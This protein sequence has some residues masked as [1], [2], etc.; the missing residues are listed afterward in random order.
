MA[1]DSDPFVRLHITPLDAELIKSVIPAPVLPLARKVSYHTILTFPEKRY[2]FVELP[3]AD[4]EKLKKKYN[5]VTFKGSKMRIEKARPE[6]RAQPAGDEDKDRKKRE[7]REQK[8]QKEEQEEDKAKADNEGAAK[9]SSKKRKREVDVLEG[10]ALRDRK[11]KRG[12]TE[13]AGEQQKKRRRS[14]KDDEKRED[15]GRDR[16]RDRDGK[17]KK[18][19]PQSKYTEGEECLLKVKVPPNAMKNVQP[20]DLQPSKKKKTKG[21]ARQV[22]VHEFEKTTKFPGFLRQ[23]AAAD[24][25]RAAE[26]V[27]G[28]GWVDEEGN[29]VEAVEEKKK[30]KKKEEEAEAREKPS[31]PKAKPAPPKPESDEEEDSGTSSEETSSD[32]SSSDGDSDEELEAAPAPAQSEKTPTQKQAGQRESDDEG[33][34]SSSGSS[35]SSEDEPD[36]DDIPAPQPKT[37]NNQANSA[38]QQNPSA[39]KA[40]HK[41]LA[42]HIP[43]AAETPSAPQAPHPLEALYKRAA[44]AA[45][46]PAAAGPAEPFSFFG[47]GASGDDDIDEDIEVDNEHNDIDEAADLVPDMPMTPFTR[48]DYEWRRVRSAAPT[49]DTAHPPRLQ[50]FSAS[51]SASVSNPNLHPLGT[52]TPQKQWG[53]DAYAEG[54]EDEEE[55]EALLEEDEDVQG[56]ATAASDFQKWFWENRRELNRSWM[57]RR[58]A[59]A[60]EKRHWEN[61]ARAS[62]AV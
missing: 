41:A 43:T 13:M 15:G 58:K 3:A 11:V 28:K 60:K 44:P 33:E 4:A 24:R 6:E 27:E 38:E 52:P 53:A 49:P 42:L 37:Q 48:Q 56:P 9:K 17:Q 7:R 19:R 10:V 29:V 62:K 32:E 1:A 18:K 35:S 25:R 57:S 20:A 2:G 45:E 21:A 34:T 47:A 16:D 26:F 36:D 5:G 8:K 55:E 22:T 54:E 14:K 40:E 30:E 59:A 23:A 31:K 46:A 61:K 39:K 50:G 51:A 12:W